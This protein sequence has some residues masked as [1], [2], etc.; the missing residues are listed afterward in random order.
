MEMPA[1]SGDDTDAVDGSIESTL[2]PSRRR[3]LLASPL[4]R[5]PTEL[6]LEVFAHVIELYDNGYNFD[7]DYRRPHDRTLFVLTAICHQLREV[8]I[9]SPRL[10]SSVDFT[11]IPIAEL[12]L[13]RC[14]Y[15]PH[16]FLIKESGPRQPRAAHDPR[17]GAVWE[18]LEGRTFNNLRSLVFEGT[19]R[20]FALRVISLLQRAPNASNLDFTNISFRPSL[21]LPQLISDPIPNLS[22]LRLHNFLI[23][24]ASPLLRNLTRLTLGSERPR[25]P[26]ERVSIE[27]FLTALANCPNLEIL[28]LTHT[29]PEPFDSHQTKC[30]VVVQ[31]RRLRELSLKFYDPSTVGCI[32]LHIRY[33]ESTKLAVYVPVGVHTDLSETISQVLPD[34]NVQAIQHF[35]QSTALTVYLDNHPHFFTDNALI[36]FEKS[37]LQE[38]YLRPQRNPQQ[39]VR[40]A[41][42]V[43]EVIGGDT[44][45]SLIIEAWGNGPPDEIWEAFLHGFPL[46]EQICYHRKWGVANRDRVNPFVLVF[47]RPFE[48][49][50]ACPWLQHL[51]LPR[52][53]LTKASAAVLKCALKE[54]NAC[55]RRL[56]RIGLSDDVT[57]V[58]DQLVLEP[59]RDL[60]D[61]VE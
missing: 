28:N 30:D 1:Q 8:G 32:L 59:F 38:P 13:E 61:E 48:G 58:G 17:R 4:L 49:G 52:V 57:E 21:E 16:I 6:V 19:E 7:D 20:E 40:F 43:V 60:V 42:K 51:E 9:T 44:I 11:T 53:A 2:H 41:S 34:R 54:R 55:G 24:W 5:L 27:M 47:S 45:I 33:P 3:N 50:S 36:H 31:L 12:F 37:Y 26:P 10:W 23:N 39:L 25:I 35:R 18:K 46:L 15:D 14:N 22:T 56:K 29:R